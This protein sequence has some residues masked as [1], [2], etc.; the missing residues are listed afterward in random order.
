[1]ENSKSKLTF[2]LEK[3]LREKF[4]GDETAEKFLRRFEQGKL[5]KRENS[6]SHLCASFAAYD[7]QAKRVFIGHHKKSGLWLFN[8]GHVDENETLKE[9]LVREINEEWGLD[10]NDFQIGH[11][12]LLT[13]TEIDNPTKQPCNFHFDF[14]CFVKVDKNSFAPI[15]SNLQEEFHEYGWKS[16]SEARN[17]MTD[18][19]QLLA[20]DFLENN[21]FI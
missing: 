9:T 20:I 13:I 3:L 15:E 2:E 21:Y 18:K 4:A 6:K 8:G 17:L 16:L 19:N 10:G 11:P 5:T 1:M 12:E 14:W 7:L